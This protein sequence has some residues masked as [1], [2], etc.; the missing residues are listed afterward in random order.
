[1]WWLEIPP[2]MLKNTLKNW[3]E[4]KLDSYVSLTFQIEADIKLITT[5][6]PAFFSL[7]LFLSTGSS[8]SSFVHIIKV[9]NTAVCS[10]AAKL[11][12]Q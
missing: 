3:S 7:S 6:F 4:N 5:L 11:M 2:K 12:T 1:M 8:S 9:F 10:N